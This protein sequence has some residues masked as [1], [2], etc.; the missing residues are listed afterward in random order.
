MFWGEGH[1]PGLKDIV[2]DEG[3]CFGVKDILLDEGH[4]FGARD[5]SWIKDIFLG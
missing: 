3:N 1:R 4:C 5:I 2:R